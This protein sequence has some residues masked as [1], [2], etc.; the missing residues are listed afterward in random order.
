MSSQDSGVRPDMYLARQPSGM[1]LQAHIRTR[2]LK[3]VYAFDDGEAR[4]VM[5]LSRLVLKF[6]SWPF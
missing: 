3:D 1:H 4:E 5:P 6:P 2:S